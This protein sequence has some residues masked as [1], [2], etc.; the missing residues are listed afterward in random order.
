M[1]LT[2]ALALLTAPLQS[3]APLQ[4]TAP[5]QDTAPSTAP[6]AR[7]LASAEPWSRQEATDPS[8][9]QDEEVELVKAF[10]TLGLAALP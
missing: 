4:G 6:V 10:P 3:T 5:Q 9:A 7:S 2:L 1:L 8:K